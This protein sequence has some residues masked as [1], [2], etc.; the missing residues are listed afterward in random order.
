MDLDRHGLEW[1]MTVMERCRLRAFEL[2]TLAGARARVVTKDMVMAKAA[3]VGEMGTPFPSPFD[4]WTQDCGCSI[5]IP[6]RSSA[7]AER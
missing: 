6:A 5:C 7:P 2:V 4:G 1:L 3:E